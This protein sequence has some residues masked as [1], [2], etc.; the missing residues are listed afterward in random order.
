M[1]D[2]DLRIQD[3]I[4]IGYIYLLLLGIIRE[5]IYYGFMGV[6]IMSYSHIMDVLLGPV[7][8]LTSNPILSLIFLVLLYWVI[9][10]PRFHR[11]NREKK[12]Y[13]RLFNVEKRDQ[14]YKEKSLIPGELP[15]LA[16]GIASLLL[17][18]GIGSGYNLNKRIQSAELDI[19]DKITFVDGKSEEVR[20]IGQN[21][22]YLFYVLEGQKQVSISPI[23]GVVKR[24]E[25]KVVLGETEE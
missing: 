21:S 1:Q 20:I 9:I 19:R 23:S 24:I 13:K 16:F 14:I 8:Y 11:K 18:T 10:Q 4:S 5:S 22:T 15:L 17:G 7:A 3:Y 12:W 2:R 6:N 25:E